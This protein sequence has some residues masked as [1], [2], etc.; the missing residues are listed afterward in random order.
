[1]KTMTSCG[2]QA[3]ETGRQSNP[4]APISRLCLDIETFSSE[5]LQKTGVY[6]YAESPDFT[7]LLV[8]YSLN[9]GPVRVVKLAA[10]AI[11]PTE[12]DNNIL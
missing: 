9:G 12:W 4:P 3:A 1:M 7:V 10:G 5:N 2:K 8:G 6:R 11:L